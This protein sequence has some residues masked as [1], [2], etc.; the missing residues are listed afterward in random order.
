MEGSEG[1]EVIKWQALAVHQ[2]IAAANPL[3]KAGGGDDDGG[4]GGGGGGGGRGAG[5]LE[6]YPERQL[7]RIIQLALPR[8]D[9]GPAN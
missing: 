2:R 3:P 7:P 1:K 5:G 4:G 9:G 8:H 6:R